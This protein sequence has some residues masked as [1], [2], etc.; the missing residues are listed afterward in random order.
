M[1]TSQRLPHLAL[2]PPP[3]PSTPQALGSLTQEGR[4]ILGVMLLVTYGL[5]TREEVGTLLGG[6]GLE[7][8]PWGQ[9]GAMG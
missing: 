5:E 7:W 1:R 4:P 3:P 8:G 6:G 9:P 2:R